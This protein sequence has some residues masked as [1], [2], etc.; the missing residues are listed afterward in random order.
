MKIL[1][2]GSGA[3]E[4]AIIQSLLSEGDEHDITC[5]PGNA[6]ISHDVPCVLADAN[7]HCLVQLD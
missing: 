4:H 1:V 5:T 2:V 7:P 3:R 6:G